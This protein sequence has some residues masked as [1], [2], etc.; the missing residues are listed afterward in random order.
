MSG[1]LTGLDIFMR[2]KS[3][4]VV[5]TVVYRSYIHVPRTTYNY[6]LPTVHSTHLVRTCYR[7]VPVDIACRLVL[8]GGGGGGFYS[9]LF[10]FTF[11]IYLMKDKR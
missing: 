8:R 6:G 1:V 5:V 7:V 11:V 2:H 10:Y 9:Y 4:R 3:R